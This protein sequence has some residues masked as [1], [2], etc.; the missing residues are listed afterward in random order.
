MIHFRVGAKLVN[1]H[2]LRCFPKVHQ[3]EFGEVVC[4]VCYVRFRTHIFETVL[5]IYLC[6]PDCEKQDAVLM[7]STKSTSDFSHIYPNF[8]WNRYTKTR[9]GVDSSPLTIGDRVNC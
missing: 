4:Y 2:L 3:F 9:S 7:L 8:F 6:F 1:L 5:E